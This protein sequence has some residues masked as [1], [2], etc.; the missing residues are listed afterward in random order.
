VLLASDRLANFGMS[1]S[2]TACTPFKL[3]CHVKGQAKPTIKP[4]QES[5]QHTGLC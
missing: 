4:G 1:T 2:A 3:Q 5:R